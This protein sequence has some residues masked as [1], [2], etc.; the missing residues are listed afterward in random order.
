MNVLIYSNS[1]IGGC[2]EYAKQIANAFSINDQVNNCYALFPKDCGKECQ[3]SV[4]ILMKDKLFKGFFKLW[5]KLYFILR[6]IVN[7]IRAFKFALKNNI[8]FFI[9]NDFDQV[10]AFFWTHKFKSRNFK[11]A[12]ILHD[13]D[14]TAYFKIKSL[15]ECSM[16]KIMNIVDFAFYHEQL[17]NLSYYKNV[18]NRIIFNKIPHGIY[19][20]D[21]ID[22]EFSNF[23]KQIKNTSKIVSITG[24]IR[25]EKNY[26]IA[27]EAISKL[28]NYTLLIAGNI[29]SNSENIDDYKNFAKQKGVENKVVFINKYLSNA[30]LSSIFSESDIILLYYSKSFKSQS[31][32]LNSLSP[33]KPNLIVSNIESGMTFTVKKFQ[34]G[35]I[36]E[37]DNTQ[38]LIDAIKNFPQN[39][40]FKDN[41]NKFAEYSSWK[42]NVDIQ[43]STF[44]TTKND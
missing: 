41:W 3:H 44:K 24:N 19:P 39:N 20:A 32:I 4:D 43:I 36:A 34:L 7:P 22:N 42:R 26:K 16:Q 18:D 21:N 5:G 15:S 8:D 10:S 28:E 12:I 38:S 40:P 14:R 30:E 17:P 13:P 1:S 35:I 23:L 33:F 9:F 25:A 37:P 29:V 11:T 27:I 31:G 2:Y 6:S